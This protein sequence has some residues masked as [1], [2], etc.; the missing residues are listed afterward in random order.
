MALAKQVQTHVDSA[1]QQ[2]QLNGTR[3]T[4]KRKAV[5]GGLLRSQKAMTAYELVDYIKEELGDSLPAMS[6]Y[7]I[8]EFLEGEGLV[9]KL[10]LA[11]RYVACA[12][13]SCSHAH[14][15]P[16]FLICNQCY[17]VE[18]IDL[19]N[20]LMDSLSKNVR[21]AGFAMVSKQIEVDCICAEC[22]AEQAH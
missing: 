11:N 18:E 19:S 6:I 5:L 13:I 3:L 16:Q 8:L 4:K 9:H 17:R 15:V 12:H 7:R 22:A 1:E 20:V 21:Q 14:A 10:K 2:C